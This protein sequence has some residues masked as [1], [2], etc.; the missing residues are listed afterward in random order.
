VHQISYSRPSTFPGL[1]PLMKLLSGYFSVTTFPSK[2]YN[3]RGHSRIMRECV[4]ITIGVS[5]F[6][7]LILLKRRYYILA[8]SW[9]QVTCRLIGKITGWLS[10]D[11][12]GKL[13]LAACCS[14]E[15][16]L[17]ESGF[18]GA[19]YSF[20]LALLPLSLRS[21]EGFSNTVSGSSTFFKYSH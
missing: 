13:P 8:V 18:Y 11:S 16:L 7:Y 17:R 1:P 20:D 10:H 21:S 3:S 9:I 5:S 15:S 2:D 19:W 12:S 4:T 14:T 6:H